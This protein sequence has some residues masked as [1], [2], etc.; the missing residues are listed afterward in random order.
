[1]FDYKFNENEASRLFRPLAFDADTD[2]F[3]C[4]DNMLAFSF[5][6][7]PTSGWD[8]QM[9]STIELLLSQDPYPTTSLLSFSLWASPDVREFLKGSDYLRSSCREVLHREVHD[10][11]L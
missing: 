6:C 4:D 11:A 8:T 3:L 7:Q 1:M 2:L 9:L 10:N 5:V